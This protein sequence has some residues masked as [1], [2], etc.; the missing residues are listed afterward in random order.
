MTDQRSHDDLDV[1][2][3]AQEELAEMESRWK[4]AAAD[5]ANYRRRAER[6]MA[7][8]R[9]HE[10][11]AI[12]RD[13]LSVVDNL[14]RALAHRDHTTPESLWGGLEAIRQQAL[15][16]L[17]HYEVSRMQTIGRRFDP[18]QHE[19]VSLAPGASEGTILDEVSPGYRIGETTLRP[20]QVIVA[21]TEEGRHDGI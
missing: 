1:A 19:A 6:D 10:R 4:R 7:Q 15:D 16:I 9:Q 5:L 3:T 21:T 12:L 20:A 8:Q 2:Q 17:G 13:W 18:L 14:E 11:E